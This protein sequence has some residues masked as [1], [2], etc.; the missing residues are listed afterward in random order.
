MIDDLALSDTDV[1]D[2]AELLLF[3]IVHE[4]SFPMDTAVLERELSLPAHV[5]K[6]RK[7]IR[8]EVLRIRWHSPGDPR[9]VGDGPPPSPAGLR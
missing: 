8:S 3:E 7:K 6:L 9:G 4:K 2:A 5:E 1:A